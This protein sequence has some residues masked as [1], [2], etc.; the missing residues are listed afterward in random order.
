[1]IKRCS[2][3]EGFDSGQDEEIPVERYRTI[4][5][6]IPQ[7]TLPARREQDPTLY[8]RFRLDPC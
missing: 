1:M 4:S 5:V 3:Q 8:P 7:H 6:A 2:S